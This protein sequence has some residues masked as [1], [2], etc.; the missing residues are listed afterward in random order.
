MRLR[1]FVGAKEARVRQDMSGSLD[2]LGRK[3]EA[4]ARCLNYPRHPWYNVYHGPASAIAV[5][6]I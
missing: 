3:G 1:C 4:S 2:M 5:R 6:V